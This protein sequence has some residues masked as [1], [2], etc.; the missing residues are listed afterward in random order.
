MKEFALIR[1]SKTKTEISGPDAES[2]SEWRNTAL[3]HSEHTVLTVK[4][5]DGIILL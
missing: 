2:D 3:H 5:G 4:Y 1:Y